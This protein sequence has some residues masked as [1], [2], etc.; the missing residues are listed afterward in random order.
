M[1][2]WNNISSANIQN[3]PG[4]Y[5]WY[6]DITLSKPDINRLIEKLNNKDNDGYTDKKLEVQVFL[7]KHLFGYFRESPYEAKLNGSLMPTFQGR[8]SHVDSVSNSLVERVLDEPSILFEVKA[9][10]A[11]TSLFFSSPIYIGMSDDL[12]SRVT[13]HKILIEK[14]KREQVTNQNFTDRDESFAARIV[15]RGMIETR[16]ILVVKYTEGNN[17]IS[18]ITENILNRIN[19]PILGRN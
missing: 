17:N 16:L 5:A 9:I 11:E 18:N 4:I 13:K 12:Y 7:E 15:A 2:K 10:L 19:Y 8:L 3:K 6:Y 1:Y 14:F